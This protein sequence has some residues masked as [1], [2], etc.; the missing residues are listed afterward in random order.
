MLDSLPR[1]VFLG[2]MQ[3]AL[4]SMEK[5]NDSLNSYPKDADIELVKWPIFATGLVANAFTMTGVATQALEIAKHD[6]GNVYDPQGIANYI[7][8]TALTVLGTQVL[9][10]AAYDMYTKLDKELGGN[11]EGIANLMDTLSG[12]TAETKAKSR[13]RPKKD[14]FPS[15][16]DV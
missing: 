9:A 1:N 14:T 2:A 6:P 4:D 8:Y 16:L 3:I 5:I 7:Q 15:K 11:I 13:K 10:A 12:I